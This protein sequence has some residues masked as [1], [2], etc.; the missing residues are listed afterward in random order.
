MISSSEASPPTSSSISSSTNASTE[1]DSSMNSGKKIDQII[2][3]DCKY[4][5][6]GELLR[7]PTSGNYA[8]RVS[9]HEHDFVKENTSVI[10]PHLA[11]IIDNLQCRCFM[12]ILPEI[13]RAW[14]TID[15][16]LCM[17]DYT[18]GTD[19]NWYD[20]QDQI[21]CCVGLVNPRPDIFGDHIK[22]LLILTT[23]ISVS[24][25]AVSITS[26]PYKDGTDDE[27]TLI[28]TDIAAP[29]NNVTFTQVVGTDQGRVFLVGDGQVFELDYLRQSTWFGRT[30]D[31]VAR[32]V[33]PYS[34]YLPT[35]F[36]QN[37]LAEVESIAIDNERK[38]LYIL[39]TQS[40]IEVYY[41]GPNGNEFTPVARNTD[42]LN[43]ARL[44]CRQSSANM[45][46]DG[47]KIQSIHVISKAE[48]NKIHL[49]AVTVTGFR[50]YFT[51]QKD[52]LRT[53]QPLNVRGQPTSQQ[54]PLPPNALELVHVRFPPTVEA[55][56]QGSALQGLQQSHLFG[57]VNAAYYD[58]GAL[59][60]AKKLDQRQD[61]KTV[62][63]MT[64]LDLG[65]YS[66]Q[67]M[68]TAH[69]PAQPNTLT[70]TTTN[71]IQRT[72]L[73]ETST[74]IVSDGNVYAIAEAN[75]QKRGKRTINEI[76]EHLSESP[77][78][79]LV[80]TDKGVTFFKKQRPVDILQQLLIDTQG[81][82][83]AHRREFD[84][85]FERYGRIQSCAMCLDIICGNL[86]KTELVPVIRAAASLFFEFGGSPTAAAAT[87]P[88]GNYFGRA[89]GSNGTTFSGKHDGFILYFARLIAPVWKL[90]VFGDSADRKKNE[91]R[92][93]FQALLLKSQCELDSL[94]RFM[95]ANPDFHVSA[96][97]ADSRFQSADQGMLQILVNE[98][99]SLHGLYLLLIH[100][101][102][103][104]SFL[105][106]LIDASIQEIVQWLPEQARNDVQNLTLD[107]M[108]STP[109]GRVLTR[110]LVIA[111][112]NKY[113]AQHMHVGYDIVS[114]VLRRKCSS[115]F[116][117]SDVAFYRGVENLQRAKK[118]EAEYERT[119]ALSE[120]LILFKEAADY[121][122][123]EK[124]VEICNDY[125]QQRFHVGCVEL[126]LERAKKIDP[127]QQGLA[128]MEAKNPM[129]DARLHYYEGRMRCYQLVFN[130][131]AAV[132]TLAESKQLL[133]QSSMGG[134][135]GSEP[136]SM[137]D[138][139]VYVAQVFSTALSH[140]DKLFHYAL[141][142]WFQ[143]KNM[144]SELL[145]V[146]TP[147]LI[148]YFKEYVDE[149]DGMEFLW[150]YYRRREQ[151]YEAALYLEALATRPTNGLPLTKRLEHLAMAVVNAS[152][153]DAKRQQLQESTQL[154]QNLEH[155]VAVARIQLRL[156]QTLA[157]RGGSENE[158][159]A[160][161]LDSQLFD[162]SD[163]FNK[164]A[165]RYVV[166]DE[167][168]FIMK[169]TEQYD[170]VYL[171]EIWQAV[172]TQN[173]K[174]A[175]ELQ[176][177]PFNSLKT[178]IIFLGD[179]LY[180]SP[181]A[182]PVDLIVDILEHYCFEHRRQ[183]P[184]GYVVE[185]LRAAGVPLDVLL[186]VYS[187]SIESKK[188]AW[189]SPDECDYLQHQLHY[190]KQLLG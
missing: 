163:L 150:Q 148:P 168:L 72:T 116:G 175:T 170:M 11:E 86:H 180:P 158:Q 82:V 16:R 138:P 55:S 114:D 42:I 38:V 165:R 189:H 123:E 87:S 32:T 45:N 111:T 63:I 162:I 143:E 185:S 115:F 34:S 107:Q 179:R 106:F 70:T 152:C 182:F 75:P 122:T 61:Q 160:R 94:K 128:Y 2:E 31:L 73:V 69:T 49:L 101:I 155:R 102:E 26:G 51:H 119:S 1:H 46:A 167:I 121:L 84:L 64:S 10:P 144:L 151:Y 33:K 186:D 140:K 95:D 80:L 176:M 96:S 157:S 4:P 8:K 15:H 125:A 183:V 154:L 20:D 147:Y 57:E 35:Y 79:F 190:L 30:N 17:W 93:K 171:K 78:R 169:V 136:S 166:L 66:N 164:F 90:K 100:C 18:D 135:T 117:P 145:A 6:L 88:S 71:A 112:I 67:L 174:E 13:N 50:L 159:G 98:Q 14:V 118:A 9:Q 59:L 146:D 7:G 81:D 141:Y 109:R 161:S 113:G 124:L 83:M 68:M 153:R 60:A 172:I 54:Q 22:Y 5:D 65:D 36:R 132:K 133:P 131:L 97:F 181:A 47:F 39:T 99:Q 92:S 103:A 24:V 177:S 156:Q 173:E 129:G 178:R 41:L 19:L 37:T 139:Q 23:R 91:E 130:A 77:R 187:V 104:I 40:G 62:L 110:E 52:A 3:R 48:S 43:S 74:T 184:A 76:T 89:L 188:P 12:G 56:G 29:T 142:R 58:C 126:P 85:F 149:V 120:S 28:A 134:T 53:I 137:T 25:L 21:L 105:D 108:L 44:A 127:Q 27:I